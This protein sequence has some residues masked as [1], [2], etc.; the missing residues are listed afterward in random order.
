MKKLLPRLV[1][2]AAVAA[3]L[4]SVQASV[5]TFD[6]VIDSSNAGFFPLMGHLDEFT[7]QGYWVDTFS[8]KAG[9]QPGDLVGALL[10]GSDLANTCAGLV[11]PTGNTSKFLAALNDGLPDIGRLDGG[12]FRLT[13]FDASFIAASGDAVPTTSLL[14]R[15]EGY[16]TSALLFQQDFFLP[17]PVNGA[18][19]FATY[20]LS[21]VNAETSVNDIAFRGFA[22]N[23]A[24]SCSRAL[25]KAQ[26]AIDNF[27]VPE[28]ASWLLVGLQLVAMGALARRR[29]VNAA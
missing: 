3:C 8:T 2:A 14:L 17:G 25:D 5:I 18:Y 27:T 7:T 1:I 16:S 9:R 10:D 6:E 29:A 24:G 19:N 26:F 11:C 20:A 4:G 13:Q 15:V 12:A 21:T 28:P 22:C 23:A